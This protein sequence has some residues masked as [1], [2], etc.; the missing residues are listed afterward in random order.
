[1]PQAEIRASSKRLRARSV[2]GRPCAQAWRVGMA[3]RRP[4]VPRAKR[5]APSRAAD[6]A[7]ERPQRPEKP[8]LRCCYLLKS[9]GSRGS[10]YIGFTVNPSRRVRQ[11]NGEILG[12]ARHTRKHRPWEMVAFVHGFSSK[13]AALQFEWAWQHPTV[14]R[15]THRGRARGREVRPVQTRVCVPRPHRSRSRCATRW[16]TSRSGSTPT[17]LTC[18]CRCSGSCWPLSHGAMSPSACTSYAEHSHR[19]PPP[20]PTRVARPAVRPLR[21]CLRPCVCLLRR[22]LR[23][24]R[25]SSARS[26]GCCSAGRSACPRTSG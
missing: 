14:R 4:V 24:P 18:A 16:A 2:G 7:A 11:H 9:L 1:M 8:G 22:C 25:R 15:R 6:G 23:C 19:R 20:L 26:R 12:G 5:R 17:R 10:T 21:P 3:R 13:V